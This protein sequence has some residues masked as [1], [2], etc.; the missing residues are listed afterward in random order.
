MRD[1]VASKGAVLSMEQCSSWLARNTNVPTVNQPR[2]PVKTRLYARHLSFTTKVPQVNH[3]AGLS[4]AVSP[5]FSSQPLA[6][7]PVLAEG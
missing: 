4:V 7:I 3:A 2:N 6:L 5:R 1:L